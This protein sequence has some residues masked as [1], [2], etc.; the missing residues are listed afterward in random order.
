[1]STIAQF[2]RQD[3]SQEEKNTPKWI[4]QHLDYAEF[5]LQC[6]D[7][8]KAKASRLYRSY[9]GRTISNS[10]R[11]IVSTY[12]RKNRVNYVDYRLGKTKLDML[13][14][15]FLL[16]P[17]NSTVRT[18]NADAKS[19]KLDQAEMAMGAA[20]S[21]EAIEKLRE[22]GV[23]PLNGMDIPSKET[24]FAKM[25]FKD[26]NE[27]VMQTI[28]DAQ[29]K[30][31]GMRQKFSDNFRDVTI[32]A[33]C[34]G[35]IVVDPNTGD[36]DYETFDE[37]DAIYEE[38]E[39]DMFLDKS[40]IMGRKKRMPIHKV[41]SRYS[42][43]TEQRN[44][45]D[46]IKGDS[47]K[48]ANNSDYKNR[49][50]YV[51]GDFCVDVVHI[52]WVS[53]T[54]VVVKKSPATQTQLAL[55]PD[56]KFFE[57]EIDPKSYEKNKK[58]HDKAVERG[59]YEIE[60][61]YKED[62]Y[63]ATRIGH[64]IDIEGRK[65]PFTM[66]SEDA[67]GNIFGKSY[68]G[69]LFNMVDGDRVSLQE[70]IENFSNVFNI[71]VYQILKELNRAKGKAIVYDRAGLPKK[72]TIK[73]VLYQL[74]NDSFIDW[75][76]SAA[77]NTSG[78]NLDISQMIKELDLGLSSSFPQLIALKQDIQ[79][80]ID[81]LSGINENREGIIAASSTA[82]NAQSSIQAS[83]TMTKHMDYATGL[84]IEK[85]LTK[86]AETTKVS[87]GLF[88][89]EKGEIILGAEKFK[90]MRATSD[91]A[92][93]DYAVYLDDGGRFLEVKQQM[94]LYMEASLNAKE[95]RPQDVLEL[96][97]SESLSE[98]KSILKNSYEVLEKARQEEQGRA[99]EAQS[100]N[101]QAQMQGQQQLAQEDREDRQLHD[102]D[103]IDKQ[104]DADIRVGRAQDSGKSILEDQKSEQKEFEQS[105]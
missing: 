79:N 27:D 77:G 44:K 88:K 26:K 16:R 93:S 40:P 41:L 37:R 5:L 86:I 1:M 25:S 61:L 53:V 18:V 63:E 55:N 3:V 36:V 104:A 17:M 30:E 85:V 59:L 32:V 45:L 6:Y 43:N 51:D 57:I 60:V 12:G 29:I 38:V 7:A 98:A 23:D 89:A 11:H 10:I 42:L 92:Y 39:R 95:I 66:R 71:T 69:M 4:G 94:R 73:K 52:E 28:I 48:Y 80:T 34:F 78:R 70:T 35:Q 49:Y 2:P 75:D 19:R 46:E 96:E 103:K 47:D 91:I 82:T 64:D 76:S 81:R 102:I 84:F 105:I 14:G 68:T 15:E 8:R 97:L 21:K 101:A 65:K 56:K 87:W 90:F 31:L 50:S 83:R 13:H 33:S 20:H 54:P 72:T 100:Q 22:N 99:L 58:K 74:A 67:P 9:N 24:P 62:L